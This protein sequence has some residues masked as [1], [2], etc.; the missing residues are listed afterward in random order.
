MHVLI[1][2]VQMSKLTLSVDERVIARAKLYAKQRGISI[3]EMVEAY[4]SAVSGSAPPAPDEGT[5]I[6]QSVRGI[7]K[8]ANPQDYKKHLSAKYR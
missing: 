7:L 3:S 8:H 6:L 1:S 2:Y 5:P 4:L